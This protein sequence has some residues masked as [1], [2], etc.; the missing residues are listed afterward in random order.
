MEPT[1]EKLVGVHNYN[2]LFPT[3]LQ[4]HFYNTHNQSGPCLLLLPFAVKIEKEQK[5]VSI[6][7]SRSLYMANSSSPVPQLLL[8]LSKHNLFY[9]MDIMLY[10]GTAFCTMVV[11]CNYLVRFIRSRIF[12][13]FLSMLYLFVHFLRLVLL[14]SE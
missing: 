7:F 6:S 5:N 14:H 12:Y 11:V 2:I 3:L 13:W 10:F 8:L 1:D 9:L 4:P